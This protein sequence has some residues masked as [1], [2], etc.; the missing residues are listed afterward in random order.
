GGYECGSTRFVDAA[1]A[2][3]N[4][5]HQAVHLEFVSF[6]DRTEHGGKFVGAVG[7]VAGTG[8]NHGED[9]N[10]DCGADCSHEIRRRSQAADGQIGAELDAA[11][12]AALGS[13]CAFGG[14]DADFEEQSL[15][16]GGVQFAIFLRRAARASRWR[17]YSSRKFPGAP[18]HSKPT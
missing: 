16:D 2:S 3:E 4:A 8:P 11:A 15:V 12:A 7:E 10:L 14:F 1:I 6:L 13:D 18:R 5:E 9:G 17:W